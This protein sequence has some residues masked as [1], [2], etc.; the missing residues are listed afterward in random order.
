MSTKDHGDAGQGFIGRVRRLFSNTHLLDD[1]EH[2]H[3]RLVERDAAGER[4]TVLV[5]QKCGA[6]LDAHDPT[7]RRRQHLEEAKVCVD[8]GGTWWTT[9][10][11]RGI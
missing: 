9:G 11:R 7:L 10:A 5:C 3:A 6:P 2:P 4:T 8:C 1:C